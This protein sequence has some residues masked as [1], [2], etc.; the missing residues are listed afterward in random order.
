MKERYK[1]TDIQWNKIALRILR[2]LWLLMTGLFRHSL[3]LNRM[4]I[5][6]LTL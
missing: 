6:I 5:T 4:S 2:Y 1:L 3:V